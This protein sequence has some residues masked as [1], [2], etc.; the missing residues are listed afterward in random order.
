VIQN[1][2]QEKILKKAIIVYFKA[3]PPHIHLG[4]LGKSTTKCNETSQWAAHLESTQ[5]LLLH[6]TH[7]TTISI[8]KAFY[9][10]LLS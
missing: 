5:H 4:R 8:V 6:A 10:I 9:E 7:I 1:I 3:L 2:R